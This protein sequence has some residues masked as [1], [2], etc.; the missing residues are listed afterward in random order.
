MKAQ[1]I[2]IRKITGGAFVR[3]LHPNRIV[4]GMLILECGHLY[5]Y[6]RPLDNNPNPTELPCSVCAVVV[7]T[8]EAKP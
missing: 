4:R 8:E 3:E 5:Q 2:P 1:G 7:Q 6:K